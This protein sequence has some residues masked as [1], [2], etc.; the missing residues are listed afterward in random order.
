M[1]L[2]G[3]VIVITGASSGIGRACADRFA[4]AGGRLLLTARSEDK[5]KRLQADLAPGQAEIVP[6]DLTAPAD[7]ARLADA[8]IRRFGRVDILINNAGVGLYTPSFLCEPEQARQVFDLNLFAPIEL[9]RRLLPIMP[10]GATV[11]NISSITGKVPAPW[12]TLYSAS[13]FALDGYSG[14]LRM[15]LAGT[16]VH[17]VSVFPGYVDTPFSENAVEGEMPPRVQ[18]GR[19]FKIAPEQCAEAIFRGVRRRKRSV[20]TPRA[21]WLLI[22]AAR[23]AP[24]FV[25]AR[26]ARMNPVGS[27]LERKAQDR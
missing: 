8:A 2:S 18:A 4:A 21:A 22:W 19:P 10:R 25:Y 26:M 14:G 5:L 20:V 6:A 17:V 24:G 11:V 9:C 16:G 23:L 27:Q 12:Q 3:K 13:K 15:E 7:I 1:D